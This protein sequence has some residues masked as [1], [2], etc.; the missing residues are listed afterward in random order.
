MLFTG[1]LWILRHG[2]YEPPLVWFGFHLVC[3]PPL[4]ILSLAQFCPGLSL[5]GNLAN[6][7]VVALM[8]PW[9]WPV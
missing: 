3:F 4:H 2:R 9:T 6:A 8:D 5:E 7:V 1:A